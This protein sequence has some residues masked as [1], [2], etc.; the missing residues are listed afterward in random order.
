MIR[1]R[2]VSKSYGG[3]T[4]LRDLGFDVER[5][6]RVA[7]LGTNGAGKTTL[8]RCI[9]GLVT[10]EGEV[11]VDGLAAGPE[12]ADSRG[13]IG[14]VPQRPPVFD[15][16]LR[17]FV[18]FF[19]GLRGADPEA[20][21]RR[22]E[23]LDLSLEDH[24]GKPLRALSGGMLQKAL[25]GLALGTEAPVLL[26]D[27]PTASL[28]PGSRREL[29]RAVSR[30]EGDRTVLFATHRLEE[31]EALADRAL[32]LARGG[33]AFDGTPGELRRAS[34][35]GSHLWLRVPSG[36]K[37]RAARVLEGRN[38]VRAVHRNGKGVEVEVLPE[39]Q[40]AVLAEMEREGIPVLEMISRPP[41]LEALMDRIVGS[42]G[43]ASGEG[44]P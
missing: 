4:V 27:E 25:L 1:V 42:S 22:L 35:A 28:D 16:S 3:E 18:S 31:V 6:E 43:R 2:G 17:A 11:T 44:R 7:V 37:A 32:V 30:V 39:V 8:F 9:L 38:G 23:G 10:F 5:G 21:A 12:G 24:G 19:S 29:L 40:A 15:L 36:E 14:Y 26:L 33:L 34:G 41:E 20:V 13:R